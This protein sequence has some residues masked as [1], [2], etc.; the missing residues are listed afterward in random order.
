MFCSCI[1]PKEML[2]STDTGR[3]AVFKLGA[4]MD[5]C[6]ITKYLSGLSLLLEFCHFFT[7]LSLP[8]QRRLFVSAGLLL[9]LNTAQI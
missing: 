7:E 8:P 5:Q 3:F 9:L 4:M 1:V 6:Q 2:D